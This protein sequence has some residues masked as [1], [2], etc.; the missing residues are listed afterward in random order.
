MK[1]EKKKLLKMCNICNLQI[2]DKE[3]YVRITE[4][5]KG[6]EYSEGFYHLCCYREK[7]IAPRKDL[8]FLMGRANKAFDKFFKL[9]S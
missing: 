4:Y 5:R 6:K 8:N 7:I 9:T 1:K 3:D 2:F